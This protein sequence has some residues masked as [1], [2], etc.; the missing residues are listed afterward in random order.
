[1]QGAA[2]LGIGWLIGEVAGLKQRRDRRIVGLS[3]LIPDIDVAIYPLAYLWYLGDLDAAFAVYASV[4][5]RYTHGILFAALIALTAHA[6][7]TPA[8]RGRVAAL[9]FTAV[10]MH[11]ICDVFASGG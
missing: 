4:H 9:T 6:L 8:A 1:M 10:V 7:A 5:H 2:H 11:I 3:G